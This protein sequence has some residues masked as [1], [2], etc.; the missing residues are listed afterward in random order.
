M[1][2]SEAQAAYRELCFRN[3]DYVPHDDDSISA[4]LERDR[5]MAVID[6][7]AGRT[8][9]APSGPIRTGSKW[10]FVL[11]TEQP[12]FFGSTPAAARAA[13]VRAI[14]AGKV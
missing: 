4:A 12:A 7:W 9:V 14:E 8:G 5:V 13:A 1:K 11:H 10:A 2:Q 6:G 3:P